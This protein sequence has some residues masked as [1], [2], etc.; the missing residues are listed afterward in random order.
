LLKLQ[1]KYLTA[2]NDIIKCALKNVYDNPA[3]DS[4]MML[5]DYQAQD[6]DMNSELDT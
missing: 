3:Y 6:V 2:F 4:L 1:N 5:E